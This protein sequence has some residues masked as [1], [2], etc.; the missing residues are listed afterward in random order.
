MNEWLSVICEIL[1]IRNDPSA[2]IKTY[3]NFT[4]RP[5]I[6]S[7]QSLDRIRSSSLMG[8]LQVAG[9]DNDHLI[10]HLETA[11]NLHIEDLFIIVTEGDR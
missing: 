2:E 4:F 5:K 6:R 3:F 7:R 8:L 10:Q 11:M 1:L 9:Q